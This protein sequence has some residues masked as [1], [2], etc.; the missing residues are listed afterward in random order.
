LPYEYTHQGFERPW[1]TPEDRP[2]YPGKF[3]ERPFDRDALA[4]HLAPVREFQRAY[5]AKIFVGEFSVVRWAPGAAQYLGDLIALFEDYGWDWTYHAFREQSAWN[6]EFSNAT[7]MST[8]PRRCRPTARTFVRS[9][10][11]KNAR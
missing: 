10:F 8:R 4:R 6:L 11:L 1:A 9:W 3:N 2:P 5:G 7:P